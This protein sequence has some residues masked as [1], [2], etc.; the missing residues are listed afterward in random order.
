MNALFRRLAAGS[1]AGALAALI[2][3]AAAGASFPGADGLIAFTDSLGGGGEALFAADGRG[4]NRRQL[5]DPGGL[6]DTDP[7]WSADGAQ[8]A[9]TR[10]I[11]GTESRV[12]LTSATGASPRTIT[13]DDANLI[14][15]EPGFSPDG[16][17][18]VFRGR[19]EG[20]SFLSGDD[21]IYSIALDGTGLVPLTNTPGVAVQEPTF[22]PDGTRI[23][24]SRALAGAGGLG[25]S[26][27]FLLDVLSGESSLVT[28][29]R[30]NA[31]D[32]DASWRPDGK[33]LVYERERRRGPDDIA[34]IRPSGK[35]SRLMLRAPEGAEYRD[36]GY[37]PS[38]ERIALHLAQGDR[39]GI[40]TFDV[41]RKKLR[42][43]ADATENESDWQP[44]DD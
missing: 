13:P 14:E 25:P 20:S 36:A 16:T 9:F 41:R 4:R 12:M 21:E 32:D 6:V 3:P 30:P 24:Y 17:R 10:I 2:A 1:L 22:S 15:S 37:S 28:A 5:T 40:A 23:A 19:P 27:I 29:R 42:Y 26:D 8:L 39:Y 7:A 18:I 11:S 38:G 33:R 34:T 35:N 44:I 31:D 43:V